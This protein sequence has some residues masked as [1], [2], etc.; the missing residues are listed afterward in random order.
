M[1]STDFVFN[2]LRVI[3]QTSEMHSQKKK[4]IFEFSNAENNIECFSVLKLNTLYSF[5]F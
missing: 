2:S 4:K 3:C 1:D 5:E